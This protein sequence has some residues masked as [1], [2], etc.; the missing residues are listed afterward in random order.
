MTSGQFTSF[1]IDK[2]YVNREVRQR[3]ELTN[4]KELAESIAKTG[5][6][7]P[8][9]IRR[10]GELKTG[11]RRWTACKSLGWTAIPVQFVDD[12]S[13]SELHLLELEENVR[14]VDLSWQDQCKAVETYHELRAKDDPDW[15]I[16]KTAKAL[17]LSYTEVLDKKNVAK[18][19]IK[20]NDKVLSAPRY[21]IARGIV[22]RDTE[23]KKASVLD[24]IDIVEDAVKVEEKTVP[25]LHADFTE[26]QKNYSGNKFNFI[27]CDFPYGVNAN[28]HDQGAAASFGGYADSADVYWSLLDTLKLAMENVVAESAHL[29]F[30]F[31]M[32]YYT[33]TISIL[34]DMGW[35][36]QKF[37]LIWHKSDNMGILP[38][39]QRGPRR[40][41]ET[42]L[43]ASRGDRKIVRAISNVVAGATTKTIHMSEKPKPVLNKFFEMFVDEHTTM[44]DPTAGSANAVRVALNKGANTVLGLERDEEFFNRASEVFF[45][46]EL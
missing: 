13:E 7:H 33:E 22:A 42:A 18:E 15:S 34:T 44:L 41:Y 1:P 8:P 5:L 10:D 40:I 11:E 43:I 14:R 24:K 19:I 28:K 9:V 38:D 17:G 30:W 25:I 26:W 31:S 32:E 46:E 39:P 23:R 3:R 20:G 16:T 27:H 36:V 45:N 2:I 21:T 35:S 29:M 4:I 12:L 6:I 37:P